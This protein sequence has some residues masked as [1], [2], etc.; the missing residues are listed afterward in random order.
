MTYYAIT[1]NDDKYIK[2]GLV[3]KRYNNMDD[4]QIY[5]CLNIEKG[6]L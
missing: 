3:S 4:L 5:R 1:A 6:F 2:F